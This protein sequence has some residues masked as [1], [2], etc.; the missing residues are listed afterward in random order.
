M[1]S[2]EIFKKNSGHMNVWHNNFFIFTLSKAVKYDS[3]ILDLEYLII[4]GNFHSL[5]YKP[6]IIQ[7]FFKQQWVGYILSEALL[8]EIIPGFTNRFF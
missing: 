3:I 7:S 2:Q 4:L 5:W 1:M 8:K 6:Q